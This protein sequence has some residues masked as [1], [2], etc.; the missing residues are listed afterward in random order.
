MAKETVQQLDLHLD[1]ELEDTFP[2]SDPLKM[3]ASPARFSRPKS[4]I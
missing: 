3:L 4:H 2:S 1:N